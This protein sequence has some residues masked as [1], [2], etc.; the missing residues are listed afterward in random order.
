M[1]VRTILA[2]MATCM[3]CVA[4]Q[5]L[6]PASFN[7][8]IWSHF[9]ASKIASTLQNV[10]LRNLLHGLRILSTHLMSHFEECICNCHHVVWLVQGENAMKT[11]E[12]PCG[13]ISAGTTPRV[14]GNTPLTFSWHIQ[15][16]PSTIINLT[17]QE[18][19]LPVLSI[20]CWES[21]VNVKAE[22]IK[23]LCGRL[24]KLVYFSSTNVLIEFFARVLTTP[25]KLCF[26]Y[27]YGWQYE[28]HISDNDIFILENYQPPQNIYPITGNSIGAKRKFLFSADFL[29]NMRIKLYI[30]SGR[31]TVDVY[32]GPGEL[33]PFM[34]H[35]PVDSELKVDIQ[36]YLYLE[37]SISVH[38]SIDRKSSEAYIQYKSQH[39]S[40]QADIEKDIS[41]PYHFPDCT[42]H[43]MFLRHVNYGAPHTLTVSFV[44][45]GSPTSRNIMCSVKIPGKGLSIH[46]NEFTFSGPSVLY[47]TPNAPLCQF[48]GL[49]Y[50]VLPEQGHVDAPLS[51]S[52]CEDTV[53]GQQLLVGNGRLTLYV[54]YFAGYS[55][56]NAT[57][58]IH[59]GQDIHLVTRQ[60]C[61]GHL[62]ICFL[63]HKVWEYAHSTLAASPTTGTA[64]FIVDDWKAF[65][66]FNPLPLYTR[67]YS[68]AYTYIVLHFTAGSLPYPFVMGT[69]QVLIELT[70]TNRTVGITCAHKINV[71]IVTTEEGTFNPVWQRMSLESITS[72]SFE[73]LVHLAVYISIT[74]QICPL[75]RNP[76]HVV[77][78]VQLRKHKVCDVVEFSPWSSLI[79][80]DCTHLTLP[81]HLGNVSFYT[82]HVHA[83]ILSINSACLYKMCLDISILALLSTSTN[84]CDLQWKHVNLTAK[85][86][87]IVFPGKITISWQRKAFCAASQDLSRC[88]LEINI[89]IASDYLPSYHRP[90][91]SVKHLSN[92]TILQWG[93]SKEYI[94][95]KR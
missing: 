86:L 59:G 11:L 72:I 32:D 22:N 13:A 66:I 83:Y 28:Q 53:S 19:T 4:S 34:H 77:L 61:P 60:Q 52:R 56:G 38:H 2:V 8:S 45:D 68:N 65:Q 47:F 39:W 58:R 55:H 51:F 10:H 6:D 5:N 54:L 3:L 73:K 18:L 14:Y 33:S 90:Q 95:S 7:T 82:D 9:L 70:S 29:R 12:P 71:V 27:T 36:F 40:F 92:M 69:V 85:P 89:S 94:L 31:T 25:A 88:H 16:I 23:H 1:H 41:T 42:H 76:N 30:F 79:A 57:L 84:K 49:F 93:R 78:N 81:Y 21:Y 91:V 44:V 74:A 87:R 67:E 48:G 50:E 26:S 24:P 75:S 62:N 35:V 46:L 17:I 63:Q 64:V 37:T 15:M 43:R 20:Y 80:A